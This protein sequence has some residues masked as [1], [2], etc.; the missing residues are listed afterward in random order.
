MHHLHSNILKQSQCNLLCSCNREKI[1]EVKH[2]GLCHHSQGEHCSDMSIPDLRCRVP[3]TCWTLRSSSWW[4]RLIRHSDTQCCEMQWSMCASG[5]ICGEEPLKCTHYMKLYACYHRN[6]EL[7]QCW[8][9]TRFETS[10]SQRFNT[11]WNGWNQQPVST[12]A[13]NCKCID[14]PSSSFRYGLKEFWSNKYAEA[15]PSTS[16]RVLSVFGNCFI[17][18]LV[19]RRDGEHLCPFWFGCF[20]DSKHV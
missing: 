3:P 10:S 17:N 20:G 14:A 19:S 6:G 18:L 1:L 4:S 15:F 8:H 13:A 12:T 9:S 11:G 5:G 2:C 7:N 16:K